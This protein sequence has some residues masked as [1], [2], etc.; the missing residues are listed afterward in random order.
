MPETELC[1]ILTEKYEDL[2]QQLADLG[3]VV[4]AFSGGVDSS[5]LVAVAHQVLGDKVLAA[6]EVSPMYGPEELQRAEELAR[7]LGVRHVLLDSGL[8]VPQVLANSPDR[9]YHCKRSLF[10]T[11][12]ARAA[13]E[14]YAYVIEGAHV[15]DGLDYRPGLRAAEELGIKAPLRDAGFSKAEIRELSRHLGLPTADLPAQACLASRFPYG[16]RITAEKLQQVARA[17]TALRSLGFEVIRVRHYG[18]LARI[19]A[20]VAEFPRLLTDEIRE[21]VVE[22]LKGAGFTYVTLDI[23]GFRSGS[24]NEVLE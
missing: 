9:C 12:I 16:S 3:S 13:T 8:P 10:C 19:E 18:E 14:G 2:R 11:L 21:S 1:P 5:L 23:Q 7:E 17:E 20:P 22:A 24:M 15:D 4:V 6:T